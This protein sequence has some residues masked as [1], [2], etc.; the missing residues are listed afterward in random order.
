MRV[1]MYLFSYYFMCV[2][3]YMQSNIMCICSTIFKL[4]NI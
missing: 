4:Y 1:A 3:H 2:Y